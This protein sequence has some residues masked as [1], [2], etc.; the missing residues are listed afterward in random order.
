M[1]NYW[2]NLSLATRKFILSLLSLVALYAAAYILLPD[3]IIRL[4]F[5]AIAGWQVGAWVQAVMDRYVK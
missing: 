2:N 5:A 1:T 3:V 4:I